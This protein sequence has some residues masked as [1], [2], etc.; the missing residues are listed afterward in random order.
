MLWDRFSDK[1]MARIDLIVPAFN[2]EA[3]IEPLVKTVGSVMDR[4]SSHEFRLIIVDDGSRDGTLKKLSDL[5]EV[6][7]RL[8]VVS[9][10]R[11]F[12]H[13]AALAAGL[14]VSDGDAC[15][16]MDADLQ[17]PPDL[18]GA[19]VEKWEAGFDVV[20]A[21]RSDRRSDSI[22]KRSTALVFYRLMNYLSGKIEIP[23]N[24]GNY[25][26]LSARARDH[27]NSLPERVRVFRVLVP[28][29]GFPT[30]QVPYVRPVRLTGSTHYNW[31]SMVRLAVDGITSA[32][33][34]PLRFAINIGLVVSS[35]SFLYLLFVLYLALFT[36]RTVQG[37][38][39]LMSVILFIGGVQLFFIGV[40]G[41]YI[42]RLFHEVKARPAYL[43]REHWRCRLPAGEGAPVQRVVSKPPNSGLSQ[44]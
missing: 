6:E 21:F 11:N 14:M 12:G 24:V 23:E 28:Y 32:T 41:E 18:I 5:R 31:A 3:S 42:G 40:L 25:R 35:M 9:L 4:L 8:E 17:D 1:P 22:A 38:P 36:E 39:S 20:N 29:L 13:E 10:S 16:V 7:A 19:L 15:I 2:E 44:S 26:L 37:W 27:L 33:T 43:V 34:I 30:A